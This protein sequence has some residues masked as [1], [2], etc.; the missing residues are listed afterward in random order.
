[1]QVGDATAPDK[2]YCA[3]NS[4]QTTSD[5]FVHSENFQPHNFY[6]AQA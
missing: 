3:R 2:A 6:T 1:V 5:K 4:S